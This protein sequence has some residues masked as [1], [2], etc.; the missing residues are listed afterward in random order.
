M[1]SKNISQGT[2]DTNKDCEGGGVLNSKY[3]GKEKYILVIN[4]G[5]YNVAKAMFF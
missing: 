2:K 3:L 4:K 1:N 5:E